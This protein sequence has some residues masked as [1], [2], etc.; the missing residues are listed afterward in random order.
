LFETRHGTAG[1]VCVRRSA[2]EGFAHLIDD[3]AQ[4]AALI[5]ANLLFDRAG[6]ARLNVQKALAAEGLSAP[7]N[8]IDVDTPE[9]AAAHRFLG[10][11]SVRINGGD[12]EAG[13]E[14][15]DSFG[16]MCRTYA[17]GA[18]AAGAPSVEMIRG[19]LRLALRG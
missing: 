18:A 1:V 10:S 8:H 15:R 19:A 17:N 4:R 7:V 14:E 11:P 3:R 2:Q 12:I 5:G 9:K 6:Q 16:L 13:A